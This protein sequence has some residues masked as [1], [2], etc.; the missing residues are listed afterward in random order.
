MPARLH[1]VN[2]EYLKNGSDDE[3][4]GVEKETVEMYDLM[5]KHGS[6]IKAY[7]R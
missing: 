6:S 5:H 4:A 2:V 1:K 7:S 3:D